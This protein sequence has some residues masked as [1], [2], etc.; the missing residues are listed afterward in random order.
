MS[1]IQKAPK[2]SKVR[3]HF[4]FDLVSFVDIP[5]LNDSR[6]TQKELKLA[7]DNHLHSLTKEQLITL[8]FLRDVYVEKV[9]APK[10]YGGLIRDRAILGGEDRAQRDGELSSSQPFGTGHNIIEDDGDSYID[11]DGEPYLEATGET[12]G[13]DEPDEAA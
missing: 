2:T 11:S 4:N 10:M 8:L 12:V 6:F 3:V 9:N 5:N 1:F 13:N 7:V